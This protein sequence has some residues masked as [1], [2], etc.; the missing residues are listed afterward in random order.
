MLAAIDLSSRTFRRIRINFLWAIIYNLLGIPLAAGAFV[1]LGIALQPWMASVAMAFSS[2][3]VVCSSLL[4]KWCVLH[5]VLVCV[6]LLR[7][8]CLHSY[9]CVHAC[10]C[11]CACVIHMNSYTPYT[12][13]HIHVHTHTAIVSHWWMS[14][15]RVYQCSPVAMD[16]TTLPSYRAGQGLATPPGADACSGGWDWTCWAVH[17]PFLLLL[18]LPTAPKRVLTC[19][20][21]TTAALHHEERNILEK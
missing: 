15:G 13:T 14:T 8:L 2:V 4:L 18:L 3:T 7:V 9:M 20:K 10:A 17:I 12:Y 6:C 16:S 19:S 21:H 11:V 5:F 1:P